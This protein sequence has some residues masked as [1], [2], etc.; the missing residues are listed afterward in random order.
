MQKDRG[1]SSYETHLTFMQPRPKP[2][3]SVDF[4]KRPA[5][6]VTVIGEVSEHTSHCKLHWLAHYF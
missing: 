2:Q 1:M 4:L 3:S 5:H 6:D